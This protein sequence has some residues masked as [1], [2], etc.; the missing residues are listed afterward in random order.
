MKRPIGLEAIIAYKLLKAVAEAGLGLLAV[1]VLV[2]GA[3]AG[4]ASAA[5]VL[6]E[7]FAGAWALSAA[8]LLVR[9]A[10]SPHVKFVAVASVGDAVLSAVE[11]LALRAGRWWAPWLVVIATGSLLPWEVWELVRRPNWV[12]A[13]ILV[14]NIAVVVYL[15]RTVVREHRAHVSARRPV[16]RQA[17]QP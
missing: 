11:G 14:L 10:T 6:I 5:E 4:A 12:R 16:D 3:E 1:W 8:T 17:P 7:H 9:A 2:R 15:L 13:V